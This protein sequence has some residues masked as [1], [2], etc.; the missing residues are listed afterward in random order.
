M[1]KTTNIAILALFRSGRISLV[2][3]TKY[4]QDKTGDYHPKLIEKQYYTP[5][6]EELHKGFKCKILTSYGWQEGEFP[7]ILFMDTLT[8][9]AAQ[10]DLFKAAKSSD[11]RVKCLEKEDIESEGFI[12]FKPNIYM[13][14][15][16]M[17]KHTPET[18]KIGIITA[19]PAKDDFFAEFNIDPY[20]VSMITIKNKSE[21]KKL[22]TQLNIPK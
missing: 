18:N 14:G 3:Y 8:G 7:G 17:V 20:A 1:D 2:E 15:N 22:L 5:D 9:F 21:F 19:D 4:I 16:I 11:I 6:I 12:E 13:K 10:S